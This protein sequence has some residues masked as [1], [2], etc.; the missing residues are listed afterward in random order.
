MKSLSEDVA[1][2]LNDARIYSCRCET[3]SVFV[4]GGGCDLV[5]FGLVGTQDG[6]GVR[7]VRRLEVGKEVC[8]KV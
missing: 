7:D 8:E 1:T 3:Y 2:D 6:E 5:W 4:G